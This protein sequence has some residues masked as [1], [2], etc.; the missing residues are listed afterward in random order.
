[1]KEKVLKTLEELGFS[2]ELAQ[3]NDGYY[4]FH[5]EGLNYLW[6]VNDD[7]PEF[8]SLSLPGILEVDD[9]N[10]E[11]GRDLI[12]RIHSSIKYIKVYLMS[13]DSVWMFY[14]RK[15]MDEEDYEKVISHMI[16]QLEGSNMYALSTY[17]KMQEEANEE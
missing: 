2:P 5:Y 11:L 15:L 14:E 8:L 6:M 9:D 3:G 4:I 10:R 7:D 13:P 12:E 16:F 1:M 17:R